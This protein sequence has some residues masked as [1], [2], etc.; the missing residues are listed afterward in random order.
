MRRRE[1]GVGLL[2]V[3][4]F[5]VPLC[6]NGGAA[7]RRPGSRVLRIRA[8]SP[9]LPPIGKCSQREEAL[10]VALRKAETPW[11]ASPE[12]GIAPPPWDRPL[13]GDDS[14]SAEARGRTDEE[15]AQ[16]DGRGAASAALCERSAPVWAGRALPWARLGRRR[17]ERH[18]FADRQRAFP[19]GAEIQRGNLAAK[20]GVGR[21][22]IREALRRLGLAGIVTVQR[23]RGAFVAD[24]S[25]G[26]SATGL[27]GAPADRRP[28]SSSDVCRHCTAHDIRTLR[29]HVE[30]Q[31]EA[32]ASGDRGRFVQLITEFHSLL[33][34][35][36]ENR[37]LET[38]VQQLAAKTS[39]AV[40]LYDWRAAGLRGRGT[41][42]ADRHAGGGRRGRR[43]GAH[44]SS[45]GGPSGALPSRK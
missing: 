4:M 27:C 13:G 19:A 43:A 16:R 11:R 9:P 41:C 20:L 38:F 6:G 28:R 18:R 35:L 24:P 29:R 25:L 42:R 44:E 7:T 30:R 12:V 34:S 32:Q 39:L 36:G 2:A 21:T 10:I 40:L 14:E 3:S 22:L 37:L 23:N 1:C 5:R 15:R 8:A 33:A 45:F 31:V 17:G 26:G